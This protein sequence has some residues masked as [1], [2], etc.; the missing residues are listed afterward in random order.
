MLDQLRSSFVYIVALLLPLAGFLL[1]G[2]RFVENDRVE[3][4][5]LAAVSL[6]GASIYVLVFF[7]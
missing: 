7:G 6:L 2:A 4:T 1:A 3:G 5:R